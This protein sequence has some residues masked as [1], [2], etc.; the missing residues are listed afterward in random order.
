MK[1]EWDEL[2]SDACFEKRGFDFEYVIQAFFDPKRAVKPDLRYDYGEDRFE[3]L[4]KID[5]R[6]FVVI[7]TLRTDVLRIISARKANAKKVQ[8]YEN[9]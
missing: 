6:V 9:H 7:Y 8:Q 3:L 2:K 1:F 5:G 4:G